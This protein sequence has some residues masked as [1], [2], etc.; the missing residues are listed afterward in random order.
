MCSPI[1]FTRPGAANTS[2]SA[3]KRRA[4]FSLI[5]VTS[6]MQLLYKLK[7]LQS[8]RKRFESQSSI[9]NLTREPEFGPIL[10]RRRSRASR[11]GRY[12]ARGRRSAGA[13]PARFRPA[14]ISQPES[15]IG[16]LL[17]HRNVSQ[18]GGEDGGGISPHNPPAARGRKVY[19]R[20]HPPSR[21]RSSS[22]SFPRARLWSCGQECARPGA[23]SRDRA[24]Y[25][26]VTSGHGLRQHNSVAGLDREAGM[27]RP[28][29]LDRDLR[30]IAQSIG[31][32][33]ADSRAAIAA[34]QN[35]AEG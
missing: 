4:W 20:P 8:M 12:M 10:A 16:I 29:E 15:N 17:W 30:G 31:H 21:R 5:A 7:A 19:R 26:T 1:R 32:G 23:P 33:R 3:P 2:G 24:L 28:Q 18:S 9:P 25:Q 34:S 11:Q 6:S 35:A 13:C 14:A 27:R 22:R